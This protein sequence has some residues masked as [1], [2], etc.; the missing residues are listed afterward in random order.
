M[1]RC[2]LSTF[3]VSARF[4]L[5]R[6]LGSSSRTPRYRY[7]ET[8]WPARL[9]SRAVHHDAPSDRSSFRSIAA[10]GRAA[11]RCRTQ[12]RCF[13][14]QFFL[15][16]PRPKLAFSTSEPPVLYTSHHIS[17]PRIPS[18]RRV[19]GPRRQTAA[20]NPVAEDASKLVKITINWIFE[21]INRLPRIR[22]G[23]GLMVLIAPAFLSLQLCL[24][25]SLRGIPRKTR[26][27]TWGLRTNRS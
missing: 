23:H 4:N 12:K 2:L 20:W 14:S 27:Y 6:G 11:R 1:G 7:D 25:S 10:A 13:P 21:A 17:K 3:V 8:A 15:R 22:L 18:C 19:L 5:W 26:Q 9:N 16:L 24:K